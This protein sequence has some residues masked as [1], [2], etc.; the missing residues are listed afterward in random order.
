MTAFRHLAVSV[1]L[2]VAGLVASGTAALADPTGQSAPLQL[3]PTVLVHPAANLIDQAVLPLPVIADSFK[4]LAAAIAGQDAVIADT[5]TRCLATVI[6]FEAKGEPAD[7]QLAVAEVVINRTKSGRFPADLCAAVTQRG[8]FSFVHGHVLP[9]IDDGNR[10]ARMA[11]AIAKVAM[12]RAWESSAPHARYF[13]ARC[14]PGSARWVKVAAIGN[15]I[16]YR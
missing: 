15:H 1:A 16:F 10:Y 3:M 9:A 4:T 6:Y 14:L 7:G 11:L 5:A 2:L 8:Q 13:H 12:A